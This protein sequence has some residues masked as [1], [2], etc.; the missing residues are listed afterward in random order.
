MGLPILLQENKWP[1]LG[2]YKSLTDTWMWKLGPEA[3]QFLFLKIH[4]LNFHCSAMHMLLSS[5][6]VYFIQKWS[7]LFVYVYMCSYICVRIFTDIYCGKLYRTH[8]MQP[9]IP[10]VFAYVRV[11][12]DDRVWVYIVAWGKQIIGLTP[13]PPPLERHRPGGGECSGG[14]GLDLYHN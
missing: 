9:L 4:K 8:K 11:P 7:G 10:T 12:P 3:A 2:I 1:I 5:G 6:I 14:G 13:T